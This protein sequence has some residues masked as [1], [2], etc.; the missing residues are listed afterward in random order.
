MK[1]LNLNQ[2][3]EQFASDRLKIF[4]T[5]DLIVSFGVSQRAAGA[6]LSYN[7]KKGAV[8]RL[9]PNL[10]AFKNNLPSAFAIANNLYCPS[11][12]SFDTALSYYNL[13]PETVYAVT[14]ATPKPTRE[15]EVDG[16]SFDYRRIKSQAFTGYIPVQ[17]DGETVYLATAEKAVADFLYVVSLGKRK[18]NDRL[19]LDRLDTIKFKKCQSLFRK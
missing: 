14:S 12:I 8:L 1:K 9:K 15:F 17:V 13:I 10:F 2:V 7:V 6:F 4:K 11:Y 16:M 5:S 19:K 3:Q 18:P